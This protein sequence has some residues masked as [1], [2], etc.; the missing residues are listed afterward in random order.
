MNK[1]KNKFLKIIF[2]ASGTSQKNGHDTLILKKLYN[3][4]KG[5]KEKILVT[6]ENYGTGWPSSG[7][8]MFS[9]F[10]KYFKKDN[11]FLIGFTSK[12]ANNKPLTGHD[13]KFEQNYYIKN[14]INLI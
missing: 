7:F 6:K 4:F 11:I 14:N 2:I 10:N 8:F 1:I 12:N 13:L 3:N 5:N 9:Y